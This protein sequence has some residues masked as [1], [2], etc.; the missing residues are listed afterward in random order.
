[1]V[2][3]DVRVDDDDISVPELNFHEIDISLIRLF[4]QQW[5]ESNPE[6]LRD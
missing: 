2:R 1:M 6:R 5:Q 4:F 3:L